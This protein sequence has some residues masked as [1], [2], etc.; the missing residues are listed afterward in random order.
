MCVYIC[1]YPNCK[2]L[3]PLLHCDISVLSVFHIHTPFK[4]TLVFWG[5]PTL[6]TKMLA[7]V[8]H[9]VSGTFPSILASA[10]LCALPESYLQKPVDN[11]ADPYMEKCSHWSAEFW[12]GA[13]CHAEGL[14]RALT[15][16]PCLLSSKTIVGAQ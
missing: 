8:H 1:V 9:V 6:K 11:E 15:T 13:G 7:I 3:E 4:D 12:C 5:V 14:R 16:T 2:G 10:C